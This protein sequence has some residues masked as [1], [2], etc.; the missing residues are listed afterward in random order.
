MTLK[1]SAA[2]GALSSAGRSASRLLAASP[3]PAGSMPVTGGTSSGDGQQLDDRVEQRL[4]ALVLERGAAEHRRDLDVEV[5]RCSERG[6]P[7]VRDLLLVEVG[8]HQLVV[9]VGAGLDQLGARVRRPASAQVLGD[10][11]V[12]ELGA[13]LVLPD[14]G[15]HL[16]QVD[17]A[18]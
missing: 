18:R 11:A 3:L 2:K 13:E 12:L 9:V 1:A 4:H 15:L 14:D 10:V 7:L 5:A 17:D 16:D 8:L 6:D